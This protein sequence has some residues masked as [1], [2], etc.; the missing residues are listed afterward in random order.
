MFSM[1]I[2]L[3]LVC[4]LPLFSLNVGFVEVLCRVKQEAKKTNKHLPRYGKTGDRL[5]SLKVGNKQKICL[6]LFYYCC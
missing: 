3:I 1:V 5:R 4:L 2:I 6:L